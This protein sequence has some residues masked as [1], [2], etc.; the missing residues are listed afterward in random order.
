MVRALS[1]QH[2]RRDG[3][4][5]SAPDRATALARLCQRQGLATEP[6]LALWLQDQNMTRAEFERLVDD[7]ACMYRSETLMSAV[8]DLH[9]LDLLRA[10]GDYG[11]LRRA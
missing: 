5:P 8:S 4:R 9:L 10:T 1:V 6:A 2:A 11:R 3:Y 7:E